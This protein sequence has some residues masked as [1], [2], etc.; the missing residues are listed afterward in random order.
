MLA[1]PSSRI[2]LLAVLLGLI[3]IVYGDAHNFNPTGQ[4]FIDPKGF[5]DCYQAQVVQVTACVEVVNKTCR[6]DQKTYKNCLQGCYSAQLAGNIGCWVQ[7]CWNQV[8]S[9]E[10]QATAIQYI[11]GIDLVQSSVQIPFY[12]APYGVP[13]RCCP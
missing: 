6:G 10:Y 11:S 12:L 3:S 13:G 7:S 8:Y 1:L 5:V 9:C 4:G 2:A